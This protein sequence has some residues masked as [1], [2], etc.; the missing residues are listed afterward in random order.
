M[1]SPK[2]KIK[3]KD[4][5]AVHSDPQKRKNLSSHENTSMSD[6]G[7]GRMVPRKNDAMF[8]ALKKYGK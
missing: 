8:E 4:D 6:V 3:E 2:K 5:D 7:K 1:T